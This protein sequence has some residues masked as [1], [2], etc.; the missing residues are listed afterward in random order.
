MEPRRFRLEGATLPELKARVL[1]EHGA[2]ATIVSAERVTVGGIRGFFAHR[3]YEVIVDVTPRRRRAAH[4]RLDL[5]SRL[6]IAALLENAD[7]AEARF[8]GATDERHLS[9]ESDG[10]ARLMDE[11]TFATAAAPPTVPGV[12][13]NDP[14]RVDAS[15]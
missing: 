9:T 8:H 14:G 12:A 5:S 11:L 2:D 3:H 13:P 1:A 4:A 6:G 15:R 7:E 10:F